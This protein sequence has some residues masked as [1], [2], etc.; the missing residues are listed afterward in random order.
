MRAGRL[1]RRATLLAAAV[2]QDATGEEVAVSWLSIATVWA[3]HVPVSGS[4]RTAG[5][6]IASS[7]TDLFR[8]RWSHQVKGLTAKHRIRFDGRDYNIESIREIGRREGLEIA[9]FTPAEKP[10]A[11]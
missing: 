3:E 4:E 6:Q 1:D 7:V 10:V 8:I 2:A 5:S 11:G 9:A